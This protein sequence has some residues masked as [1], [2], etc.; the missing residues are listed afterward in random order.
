MPPEYYTEDKMLHGGDVNFMKSGI[1]FADFVTTV[2]PTYAEEVKCPEYGENLDW[3][4]S[5]RSDKFGGIINGID[6][7]RYSPKRNTNIP[8]KY[9]VRNFVEGKAANK[10]ALQERMG[11]E[12]RPDVPVISMV[13]RL[14]SQKGLDL[15]ISAMNRL[16]HRDFQ[17]IILGTGDAEYEHA[18]QHYAHNN[19]DKMRACIT[20]SNELSHHMYAGSDMFLMPSRYEPCGLGQLISL[21]FGTL[22]IVRETGGLYDTVQSYNEVTGEGNGFSFAPYNANDMV[23]TIDRALNIYSS[24]LLWQKIVKNA[25]KC[26]YSWKVSAGHYMNIY[27]MLRG[28]V[29]GEAICYTIANEQAEVPQQEEKCKNRKEE[30]LV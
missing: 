22:P 16:S 3:V 20:F 14:T 12:Q 15:V 6:Y 27:N 25:M 17:F 24:P 4:I 28:P 23:Y 1:V 21:A 10:R 13:T 5:A 2:S 29:H 9:G 19:N 7:D 18:L 11:L 8:F 30:V 26:D